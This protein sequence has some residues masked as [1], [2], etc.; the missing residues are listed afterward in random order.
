MMMG[1][2]WR[3]GTTH[4][5]GNGLRA[6]LRLA[7]ALLLT[8]LTLSACGLFSGKEEDKTAGYSASRLY[9]EA[10]EEMQ[11]RNW[12]AAIKLFQSLQ[13][14]YP[15]GRFAQQGLME[16]AYAHYKDNEPAVARAT[17]ERFIKQYPNHPNVDYLYYLRGLASFN[18]NLGLLASLSRQD[19]TERDPKA[20][21]ESF[22]AFK[23][24]LVRFPDSRYAS[25]SE[26]R[27]RY[28]VNAMAQHEI[29]VASYYIRRG[30][31]LAAVNRAQ[32]VLKD[33]QQ[34]PAVEEALYIMT[35]G[36]DALGMTDLRDDTRKVLDKNFP[37]S[38]LPSRGLRTRDT[39]WWQLW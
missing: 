4:G 8:T 17:A 25:D 29:H 22:D 30:A 31:Y 13:S 12:Q 21:R 19:L 6:R 15:F 9:S 7:V 16:E 24:L 34:A 5:C 23:E 27:M 33:Y 37:E 10:Q 32:G 28:L 39:A 20:L 26:L 2:S 11:A 38:T 1:W 36:Y 14:R 3:E 35:L 18:D